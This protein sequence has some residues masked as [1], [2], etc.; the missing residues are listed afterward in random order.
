M[1]PVYRLG[2]F[3]SAMHANCY[4]YMTK[5]FKMLYYYWFFNHFENVIQAAV[6]LKNYTKTLTKITQTHISFKNAKAPGVGVSW[7]KALARR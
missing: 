2:V 3:C 1:K 4:P 6:I 5:L 7:T